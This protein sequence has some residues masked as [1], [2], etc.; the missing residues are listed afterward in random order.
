MTM[1]NPSRRERGSCARQA[2]PCIIPP[3]W[4]FTVISY[5]V[6]HP[7]RDHGAAIPQPSSSAFEGKLDRSAANSLD[8]RAQRVRSGF[9]C[10][11]DWSSDLPALPPAA[12][13]SH[14]YAN[15]DCG[16]RRHDSDYRA[17]RRRSLEGTRADPYCCCPTFLQNVATSGSTPSSA[18]TTRH[19]AKTFA[20]WSAGR[21]FTNCLFCSGVVP[22]LLTSTP[23]CFTPGAFGS[24]GG[25]CAKALPTPNMRTRPAAVKAR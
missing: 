6:R 15:S 16:V 2:G 3:I 1:V 21:L 7:I 11:C 17:V 20:C 4:R 12:Y 13:H 23:S 24:G 5:R 14:G 18:T 25:C 22:A 10:R 8:A 9:R 19:C